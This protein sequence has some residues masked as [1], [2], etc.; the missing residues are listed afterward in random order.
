ME[1]LVKKVGR[2]NGDEV[3]KILKAYIAKRIPRDV[4]EAM[5]LNFFCQVVVVPMHEEVENLQ[6]AHDSW[7][8]FEEA[9][10]EK[11]DYEETRERSRYKFD[12][13]VA[14]FKTHQSSTHEFLAFEYRF[15]LD[16]WGG[17]KTCGVE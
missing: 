5:K 13:W 7:E 4:N 10:L 17:S 12:L 15:V 16:S 3:P 11:Y 6:E 2:F 1:S 9:L 14:C 8:S